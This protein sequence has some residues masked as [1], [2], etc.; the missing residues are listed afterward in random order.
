MRAPCVVWLVLVVSCGSDAMREDAGID[1]GTDAGRD[2][3]R[4]AGPL[5]ACGQDEPLALASCVDRSRYE[6]DLVA[7]AHPREPASDHWQAVQDLCATRLESLG[8]EVERHDYGTGV[9]VIGTRVG[10]TTPE[11][12]VI[13]GAHYDHVAGCDGADDNASGVAGAL[14][15]ARVLAS[16]SFARTLVVACWDEEERGLIGSTAH[17]ARA[18]DA[19]ETI[20]AAFVLEMIGYT[21]DAPGSQRLA[22]GI[23]VLFPQAAR[24]IEANESRGDFIAAIGDP[25]SRAAIDALEAHADRIG[26]PF[27]RLDVPA[28]VLASPVASDLRRSDHASFWASAYPG[29]MLSDTANFRYDSYHCGAGPDVPANLDLDFAT[30]VVRVTVAAAAQIL[31]AP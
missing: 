18:R 31:D 11:R 22:T 4:D 7:I 23:D 19:G 10:T 16:R 9:N 2:G 6:R 14:E 3:G 13:V 5:P 1:A 25:A 30:R 28:S 15:I 8:F 26:L 24:E 29:L 27:V 12:R 20:D 17:A 21:S